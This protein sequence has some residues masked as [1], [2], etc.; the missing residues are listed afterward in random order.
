[1][2]LTDHDIRAR[3]LEGLVIPAHPLALTT[4][5]R[6]DERHQCALTRYYLDAGVGGIA[7]GVHTTQFAI[8]RTEIGLY[9]PVLALAQEVI[10]EHEAEG[11][12]TVVRVAGI[13]GDTR[14]AVAEAETARGLG[15]Q[16]GLVSVNEVA[17]RR[18]EDLVEHI[19]AVA[20]IMPVMGFYPQAAI[21]GREL[22]Y[23]FWRGLLELERVVAIKIAPFDRYRTLEVVR[24]VVESGRAHEVALYTGNDDHIILDLLTPFQFA[25][26][27]PVHLV[28]GLLGQWAVWTK[29]AVELHADCRR[30]VRSGGAA[31]QYLLAT[32]VE[33]S[34]ANGAIF[35]R[36]NGYT[37][38][39]PG[40]N[41]VLRRQGLVSGIRCI[42]PNAVMS[43][44]Q[45][46][47]I[48]R[49]LAAYPHLTDDE[50]V[51]KHRDRWLA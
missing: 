21:G 20:E 47:E 18:P 4:V 34:D 12:G 9:Q 36:A 19:R 31:P 40:I 17:D 27:S 28:G 42:D 7:V 6:L 46:E 48:E 37:G 26:A 15:Y 1:M 44:G 50:F 24:A 13:L 30:V 10:A 11:K 29:R 16:V 35:D 22:P 25:G 45:M 23:R 51:A 33:L 32:A 49:V 8:H 14:Q 38:C 3:L 39:L 41:E 43:P 2:L 5:G